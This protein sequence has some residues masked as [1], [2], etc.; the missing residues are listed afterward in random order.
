MDYKPN[1][2]QTHYTPMWN[3][4]MRVWR[5]NLV[6]VSPRTMPGAAAPLGFFCDLWLKWKVPY[7]FSSFFSLISASTTNVRDFGWVQAQFIT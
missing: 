6:L 1:P 3:H 5:R 2:M 4:Q 7:F